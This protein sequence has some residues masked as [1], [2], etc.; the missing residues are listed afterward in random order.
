MRTIINSI[1]MTLV[2]CIFLSVF[3]LSVLGVFA[4]VAGSGNG[5]A[6]TVTLKGRIVGA[7]NVGQQ[8]S[9]STYFW[10][11]PSYAGNGYDGSS[12]RA[13]NKGGSNAE[14][15]KEVKQ[16]MSR[17]LVC[18]PYLKQQDVPA[19]MVTAS[20]SGLDPDITPESAYIQ[21]SRIAHAR[22]CNEQ[23]VKAIINSNIER[24][25]FGILGTA[26]VNVL[27]MNMALDEA[28]IK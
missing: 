11:R 8:F 23:V 7:A 20:G 5:D 2:F 14:Y 3:Y 16:R 18:H 21:A 28:T 12:S 27:K 19:E 24:P 9:K 25:L 22:H 10:G 13:S 1:K 15:L 17:F 26:K 4:K 6:E